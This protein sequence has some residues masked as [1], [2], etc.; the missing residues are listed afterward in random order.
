MDNGNKPHSDSDSEMRS[1]LK[2]GVRGQGRLL[3]APGPL[4]PAREQ[5]TS[6]HLEDLDL[7]ASGVQVL[8][9][10]PLLV[11]GERVHLDAEGNAL[12]SAVLP[13]RELGADTVH[14]RRRTGR[15]TET[16]TRPPQPPPDPRPTAEPTWMK[17]EA[18]LSGSQRNSMV[19]R[20]RGSDRGSRTPTDRGTSE[21][22]RPDS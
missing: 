9:E 12:L 7:A 16:K 5:K 20:C 11:G 8:Q 17:T 10:L 21:D 13:G 19:F 2:S 4:R 22:Q 1:A 14:L 18:C 6:S 15:E 3:G